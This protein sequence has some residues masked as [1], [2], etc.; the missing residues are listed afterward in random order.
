MDHLGNEVFWRCR[1]LLSDTQHHKQAPNKKEN[2]YP[3]F[4][5][6][7]LL[8]YQKVLLLTR[9]FFLKIFHF[10][11]T[12]VNE[13]GGGEGWRTSPGAGVSLATHTAALALSAELSGICVFSAPP[14]YTRRYTQG[15]VEPHRRIFLYDVRKMWF[16]SSTTWR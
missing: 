14:A 5:P 1:E 4:F 11:P 6:S 9:N 15:G 7:S 2:D 16:L 8:S 13:A 10:V 3:S 12:T